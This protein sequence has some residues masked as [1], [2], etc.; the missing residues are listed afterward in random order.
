MPRRPPI[1]ISSRH[2][3]QRARPGLLRGTTA[4]GTCSLVSW[5]FFFFCEAAWDALDCTGSR[6]GPEPLPDL[7]SELLA[8]EGH[9]VDAER[10]QWRGV[11]EE[12]GD[13]L[14]VGS[15]VGRVDR[16]WWLAPV[17][18]YVSVMHGRHPIEDNVKKKKGTHRDRDG[19][20]SKRLRAVT[21]PS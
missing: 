4:R 19:R 7:D 16:M 20:V 10:T 13:D 12:P 6:T 9:P 15:V 1:R 14:D 21:A 18:L 5:D 3:Q 2:P 8:D 11:V 17:C